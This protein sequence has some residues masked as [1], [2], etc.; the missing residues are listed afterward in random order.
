MGYGCLA[1][2][3]TDATILHGVLFGVGTTAGQQAS[4]SP[5]TIFVGS[6][7]QPDTA[8]ES[9]VIFFPADPL[10][11]VPLVKKT[12]PSLNPYV[13][14]VF[15][16]PNFG[17]ISVRNAQPAEYMVEIQQGARQAFNIARET[18]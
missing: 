7:H 6:N 8:G 10:S 13:G 2:H 17:D 14:K 3:V 15:V 12:N 11:R 18:R 4:L 1:L 5:P 16:A 9:G